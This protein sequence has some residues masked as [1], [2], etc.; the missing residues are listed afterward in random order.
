MKAL[1]LLLVAVGAAA[2]SVSA[3]VKFR[4][5]AEAV[6][7]DV[8]VTDGRKPIRGLT[9]KDF[10]V[11]DLGAAQQI[12]V[13]PATGAVDVI[14]TL[15]VSDS[16]SASRLDALRRAAR[17]VI[18]LL[19]PA[20]RIQI[21]TFN[22]LVTLRSRLG[23][24]REAS[25]AA[26]DGLTS[27]GGTALRDAVFTALLSVPAPVEDRRTVQLVLSD[28]DD[29]SSWLSDAAVRT[30]LRRSPVVVYALAPESASWL[31]PALELPAILTP[32]TVSRS[33]VTYQM[34]GDRP[35]G[36]LDAGF[37]HDAARDTGGRGLY[38]DDPEATVAAF[39]EVF[40]EFRQ[41]YVITYSPT[42]E[43]KGWHPVAVTV[44]GRRATVFAR[45]GYFRD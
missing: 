13:E 24:T 1:T 39:R 45:S 40:E 17:Q 42:A 10:D 33:R 20:D 37:L 5:A 35:K 38:V 44:K 25:M 30:A 6:R 22:H 34:S 15:D 7:L 26:L 31:A 8:L 4:S 21:L 18:G 11:R 12:R 14:L 2:V 28:G 9:A 29:S 16:L 3:Q 23:S 36:A 27:S 43:A 41:R 19:K 32:G